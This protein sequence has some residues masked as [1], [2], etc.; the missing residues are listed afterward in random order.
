MGREAPVRHP[1]LRDGHHA[2]DRAADEE[3]LVEGLAH[4]AHLVQ[5]LPHPARAKRRVVRVERADAARDL[6][7][8]QRTE[9]GFGCEATRLDRVVDSLQARHV[10]E[11]APSPT[12]SRPGALN[13]RGNEWNPP[14]V[15]VFAP[16]ATR[17]PPPRIFQTSRC[18][19]NSCRTSCTENSTSFALEPRDEPDRDEL[20]AHR[21]DERAAELAVAGGLPQRPAH[22]VHDP[23]K[24]LRDAPDL[25]HAERPDLRVLALEPE[26][27]DR[28]AREEALRPLGEHGQPCDD[29]AARLEGR[30]R[31]TFSPAPAIARPD[32]DDATVLDEQ[33]RRSRLGE[34]AT[35]SASACSARNRPSSET[36]RMTVAVVPHRRRRRDAHRRAPAS[37]RTRPRPGPRRTS[38]SRPVV[39]RPRKS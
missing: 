17:S 36:E 28:R 39:S 3:A 1:P 27:L 32:A 18:V 5:L 12:S 2:R 15:I 9:R 22:R 37:A 7:T 10:D 29:V 11:P 33:L 34:H 13:R 24:R 4:V 35:P 6:P 20:V 8:L 19:L 30:K 21:I 26:L 31:L 25:L 23:P 14:S 16:H 38:G